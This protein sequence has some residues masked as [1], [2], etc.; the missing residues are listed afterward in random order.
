MCELVSHRRKVRQHKGPVDSHTT[1]THGHTRSQAHT[2]RTIIT[3]NTLAQHCLVTRAPTHMHAWHHT[4]TSARM[5]SLKHVSTSI[6]SLKHVSTLPALTSTQASTRAVLIRHFACQVC[7]ATILIAHGF[8]PDLGGAGGWLPLS[9]WAR[10]A[11]LFSAAGMAASRSRVRPR[12]TA[13]PA[14]YDLSEKD[15]GGQ[16]FLRECLQDGDLIQFK[17]GRGSEEQGTGLFAAGRASRF[18]R[19]GCGSTAFSLGAATQVGARGTAITVTRRTR[20]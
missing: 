17:I 15:S 14:W 2:V 11:G 20:T 1:H 5:H 13:L 6:H 9:W 19:R 4:S 12:A 18:T 16:L 7:P 8:L 3:L 10:T